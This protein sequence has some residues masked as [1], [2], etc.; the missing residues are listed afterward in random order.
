MKAKQRR[1]GS[2]A[3]ARAQTPI[4]VDEEAGEDNSD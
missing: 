2:G 3:A 4:A 1:S